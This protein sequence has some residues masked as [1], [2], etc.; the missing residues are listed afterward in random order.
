MSKL[1][2]TCS[3]DQAYSALP[4]SSMDLYHHTNPVFTKWI[5]ENKLLRHRLAV[6]DVGCQGG[7]HPRWMALGDCVDFHGFDP[8]TEVVDVLTDEY[9][10]LPNFRFYSMALGNEDGQRD[11]YVRADTFSSSFFH[12]GD[13][14]RAG[15]GTA[16][17]QRG[18]RS[19]EIRKLDTLRSD[20]CIPLADYIKIDCEGFEPEVLIGAK[21]FLRASAPLCVTAETN[22]NTSPT[23]LHTHFSSLNDL[24][25][26][27]G[28]RVFDLSYVRSPYS[29]YTAALAAGKYGVRE[30]RTLQIVGRPTTF[31]FVFCRDWV[32]ERDSPQSYL[33]KPLPYKLPNVDKLIKAMIIFE[34]HGLMDCAFEIGVEFR[35]LLEDRMDVSRA[36]SLLLAPAPN[37]RL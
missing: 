23:H 31:D 13:L 36:L 4:Q 20:G 33:N 35:E 3:S 12:A 15:V 29:Q 11:F 10:S 16:H 37:P 24:L 2:A 5:V 8:I 22:F 18:V 1:A 25:L 26:T 14:S 17:V 27:Y 30:M 19:V 6:I 32:A 34:L 9:R 28:L 7:P 21:D